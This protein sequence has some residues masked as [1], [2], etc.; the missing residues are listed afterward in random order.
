MLGAIKGFI[1]GATPVKI[2][3]WA[4]H[5]DDVGTPAVSAVPVPATAWLFGTGL[6]GLLGFS[7]KRRR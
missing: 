6:A 2:A 7:R 3:A 1:Y 4:V 5:D